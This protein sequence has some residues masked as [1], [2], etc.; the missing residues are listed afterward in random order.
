MYRHPLRCTTA[1]MDLQSLDLI[2]VLAQT[3]EHGMHRPLIVAVF[4]VMSSTLQQMEAY[5]YHL[6]WKKVHHLG[7]TL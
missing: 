5:Q 1:L 6:L 4:F 7:I 3:M 2:S